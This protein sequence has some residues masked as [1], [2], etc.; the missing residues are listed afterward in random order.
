MGAF[1]AETSP[2]Y[3]RTLRIPLLKGRVFTAH[4]AA[5][6]P[7]MAII[8]ETMARQFFPGED[9]I[10]ARLQADL[11]RNANQR[12]DY[13]ADQPRTIVG[14]VG[15]VKRRSL[16]KDVDSPQVRSDITPF[17]YVPYGQ[18]MDAYPGGS[19]FQV[20][21]NKQLVIRTAADPL[22]LAGAVRAAMADVD[23]NL[24]PYDIMTMDARLADSAQEERL[25]MQLLG[26]FAGL[27]VALAAIGLYGVIAYAVAQRTHELGIRTAL[28]ATR[29]DVFTLVVRQGLVLALLG[30]A[31]GIPAAVALTH[32]IASRLF[33]VTPTD[34][35]T[36]AAA[37]VLFVS[38]ALLACSIPARRATKVDP[39]VALRTE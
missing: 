6:A 5:G 28:G 9:P 22:S 3:F 39:L 32:V 14:V 31:I 36:L 29:T 21:L 38:I 15:D 18:H 13:I 4:D 8:N 26:L 16:L 33:G 34:L 2:D 24:V 17:M 7:G 12:E 11:L 10:G 35:A 25:W 19:T 23:P 1:Y 20:P 30:V 37:A 27:A